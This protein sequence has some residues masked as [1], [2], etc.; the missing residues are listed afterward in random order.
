MCTRQRHA[1]ASQE[2][3]FENVVL[4]LVTSEISPL[5][6]GERWSTESWIGGRLNCHTLQNFT[7][8]QEVYGEIQPFLFHFLS[9]GK[10]FSDK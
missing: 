8:G 4:C 3:G 7:C 1:K 9:V 2:N 5:H 10:T 6:C